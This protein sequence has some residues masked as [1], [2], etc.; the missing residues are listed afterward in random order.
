M[1]VFAGDSGIMTGEELTYDYNFDNFGE[2]RQPCYCGAHNCRGYL[3]KRLNAAEQKKQAKLEEEKRREAAAL[4][5]KAAAKE[6]AKKKEKDSR[7]SGWRGW[8]A[9]DDPEV[10]AELREKKKQAEEEAKNSSRAQRLAARARRDSMPASEAKPSPAKK[11]SSPRR[12]K[13]TA[14]D[15][16]KRRISAVAKNDE[17]VIEDE[18][19]IIVKKNALRRTSTGSRFTEDLDAEKRPASRGS[20]PSSRQSANNRATGIVKRTSYSVRSAQSSMDIRRH[21]IAEDDDN[22]TLAKQM[23]NS[24]GRSLSKVSSNM[25]DDEDRMD[26]DEQDE[27]I[28]DDDDKVE[29]VIEKPKRNSGMF[30]IFAGKLKQTKLTFG[31]AP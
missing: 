16:I 19:A 11:R 22:I 18:D 7:G 23:S 3:G 27:K 31:K 15:E 30:G 5:A 17:D 26:I 29:A 1:A 21:P 9:V 2:T 20:R 6:L 28:D 14:V 13:T 10:K 12:R 8:V 4:A 25:G 24:N